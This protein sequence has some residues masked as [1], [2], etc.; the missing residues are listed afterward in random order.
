M[1]LKAEVQQLLMAIKQEFP[2]VRPILNQ[3]DQVLIADRL[4]K[5]AALTD[6]SVCFAMSC[7]STL[8]QNV[9]LIGA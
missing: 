1:S 4:E 7:S 3:V 2:E 6:L 8:F 5:F 9:V